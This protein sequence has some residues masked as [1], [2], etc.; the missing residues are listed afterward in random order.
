MELVLEEEKEVMGRYLKNKG[1]SVR[2]LGD[3][4]K[5]V[6]T[7]VEMLVEPV[8]NTIDGTT[9]RCGRH[10]REQ[11]EGADMLQLSTSKSGWIQAAG[12][13]AR[14]NMTIWAAKHKRM[15]REGSN[16]TQEVNL[17]VKRSPRTAGGLLV[18][19]GWLSCR[20]S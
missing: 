13:G 12:H 16:D 2:R 19:I 5:G 17:G 3:W 11:A 4:V 1:A 15:K 7:R 10:L 8:N 6:T 18:Q 20:G 14:D 9:C